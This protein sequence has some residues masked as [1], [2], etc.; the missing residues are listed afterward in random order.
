MFYAQEQ[1]S[2][3]I[4]FASLDAVIGLLH[5][6]FV[7]TWCVARVIS[8]CAAILMIYDLIDC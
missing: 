6:A 1:Y 8:L 5:F 4:T 2:M 3:D 7:M